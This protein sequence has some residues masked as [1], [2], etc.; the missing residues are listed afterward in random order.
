[1]LVDIG[2]SL[3]VLPKSSLSKLTIEGLVMKPSELVVRAFDGSGRIVTEGEEDSMVS[4]L[5]SFHYVEGGGEVDET[6][7]QSFEVINV[8]M[9]APIKEGKKAE[10]S[11]AT[12][13][14]VRTVINVGPPEVLL[15]FLI[16]SFYPMQLIVPFFQAQP[17]LNENMV[18]NPKGIEYLTLTYYLIHW[19][20]LIYSSLSFVHPEVKKT[21]EDASTFK[22]PNL[23][24][25]VEVDE[26]TP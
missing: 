11:M 1:M 21:N 24:V 2:S 15:A 6:P 4:H 12:W 20:V 10:F 25:D 9:V 7:F 13:K 18:E 8:E 3:N 14:D 17:Q 19:S 23:G 16:L 5:A 22:D 26:L